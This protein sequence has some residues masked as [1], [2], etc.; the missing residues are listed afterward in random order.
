M[1]GHNIKN[2]S[3]ESNIPQEDTKKITFT[4]TAFIFDI[5]F[6]QMYRDPIGSVVREI[7]SNCFDSHI[8]AKVDDAVVIEFGEDEGGDFISFKDVGMG[9]SLD[10]MENVYKNAGE[11][12]KRDSNELIGFWGKNFLSPFEK[13]TSLKRIS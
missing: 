7:T 5:V 13:V 10:R 9:I 6:S 3:V 2:A 8:E 4:N 1:I 11:S 12:T